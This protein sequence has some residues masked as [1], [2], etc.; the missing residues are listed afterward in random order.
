[1]DDR[2][3]P[4]LQE[5]LDSAVCHPEV[6]AGTLARLETFLGP[7]AESLTEPAQRTHTREY[8]QGLFSKLVRKTGEAIAYLHDQNRQGLQKF[9]GQVPWD[10]RPLLTTLAKQIGQR[11]GE[12]DGVIV[13]DPSAFAKK[14]K[15]SVGVAR[16]WCG[17]LGKVDNCQVGVFMGYVGRRDHALVDV[18]LYL[19]KEWTGDRR[20]CA[21]A[22]VPT[23]TRFRT[24]HE[25]ALE[26]LDEQ[27]KQLPHGWVAGDDE[28][29][30]PADFRREL[31]ERN[32][33]YLLAV[34]S[35]T[36]IRDLETAPPVYAGRGR[37]AEQPFVPVRRWCAALP[38]TAWTR[39]DVRDGAKGPLAIEA[40]PC[41]VT[42]RLGQGA[43]P[44]ERL[45][46]TRELQSDGSYKR[47]YYLGHTGAAEVS[48]MELARV[49]K[50]EHCIEECLQ[51]GK[52]EAGLGDYQL[53]NWIGWHHHL[54]LSLVAAWF[55]IGETRRGKKIHAR[56]DSA[57]ST[58]PDRE[59]LGRF[60][61]VQPAGDRSTAN[62]PLATAKRGGTLLSLPYA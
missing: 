55:L 47:D 17:R 57:T 3:A 20:R 22:G 28:M 53:R 59:S 7:Y 62:D 13:F 11:I 9:I 8:V 29:G 18:R 6:T 24:R 50:A 4:R 44:E 10:H 33:R 14:G 56:A 35:N 36:R 16:Q 31:R 23:G 52:S 12:A 37:P 41:R 34:P 45:L 46:V 25:L 54:T 61:P 30:R 5:M 2:F 38:A 21:E 39:L 49:A 27:G 51:R 26:M 15:M 60:S 42:A 48:L 32:E 43:G 40:V 1:M 58:R 19:P